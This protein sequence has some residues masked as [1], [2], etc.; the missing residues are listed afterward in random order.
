[1]KEKLAQVRTL[2]ASYYKQYQDNKI[3]EC[4]AN[5]DKI[6]NECLRITPPES[7]G[8]FH[9]E[10]A[11]AYRIASRCFYKKGDSEK[12]MAM[13]SCGIRLKLSV[14]ES[15]LIQKDRIV[16]LIKAG[17]V[18]DARKTVIDMIEQMKKY[19]PTGDD[20]G[21]NGKILVKEYITLFQ[22]LETSKDNLSDSNFSEL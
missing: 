9:K 21:D 17:D 2:I 18:E 4:I 3:D 6:I 1:L 15:A 11:K 5:A 13:L 19:Y 10:I 22:N 7:Q 20:L 16:L 8:K 12:A 14:I